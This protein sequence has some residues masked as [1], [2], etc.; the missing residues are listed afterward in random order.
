[1][2]CEQYEIVEKHDTDFYSFK[3]TS[4]YYKDVIYTYGKVKLVE[5]VDQDTV[6]LKFTYRVE[7]TPVNHTVASLDQDIQF[8]NNIGAILS[9]YIE[10]NQDLFRIGG[11]PEETPEQK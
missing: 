10:R 11:M 5:N 3:I 1:M 2:S 7:E 6:T 4:G 9:D 8:K